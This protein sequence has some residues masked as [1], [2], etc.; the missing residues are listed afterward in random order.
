MET[1]RTLRHWGL[2]HPGQFPEGTPFS[3]G[4]PLHDSPLSP[5]PSPVLLPWSPSSPRS[6]FEAV[7]VLTLVS[8][9]GS[10]SS[11]GSWGGKE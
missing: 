8:P 11:P 5:G 3:D 1:G 2:P 7:E 4:D 9:E 10:R 6:L